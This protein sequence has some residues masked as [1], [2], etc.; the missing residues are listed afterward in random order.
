MFCVH[1]AEEV[2]KPLSA[3][4]FIVVSYAQVK[5]MRMG[6][7]CWPIYWPHED[8]TLNET[9]QGTSQPSIDF[10]FSLLSSPSSFP[11]PHSPLTLPSPLQ[12]PSHSIQQHTI[13]ALMYVYLLPCRDD[14]PHDQ[15][16][17]AVV[18]THIIHI[19]RW[20]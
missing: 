6:A 4:R 8:Y 1:H 2:V 7:K 14:A 15:D 3:G 19:L 16:A 12:L 18:V 9:S 5:P 10:S 13:H 20:S 11:S 17:T